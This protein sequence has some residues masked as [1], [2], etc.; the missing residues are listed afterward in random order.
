MPLPVHLLLDPACKI[1]PAWAVF[2]PGWYLHRYAEA[3]AVCAGQPELAV[4]VYYLRVG[5]RLG[6]SPSSLFDEGFYLARNPDIAE[7]VRAGNYHSG[8]DHFCQHGHR[9]TSPHWLFDDA[10]YGNLYE[11]M[12]L[13]NLDQH[14]CHGRYDHYLRS[15]QR[16]RR[17]GQ[18]LFDGGFY[19]ARAVEAGH[20]AAAI[21]A[22]GPYVHFLQR[23]G[24]GPELP[25]SIYFEP[26]WYLEQNPAA[27]AALERGLFA[28]ALHHYLC[29][30]GADFLDPV[31]QFSEQYYRQAYPDIGTAV[32]H[33][34]YRSGYQQFV[35]HGAFELRRPRADIDLMYYRDMN[36][37]VRNDLNTGEVRD[38]FAHLRLVGLKDNLA[39]CPP[40]PAP[41]VTEPATKQ[42]FLLRA[43]NNLAIFARR[44]LDFTVH[45]APD[46]TVLMVLHNK[47][48]LTMLALAS[49]RDNFS[50]GIELILVDND[51]TDDTRRIGDYVVGARILRNKTN[52]G[53]LR[54]A[55]L[56]LPH[57]TAPCLLYLN[58]DVELGHA[59]VAAALAR[60]A[61][62]ATIGA[63]A[64]KI[65]R[66]NGMLQEAGSIIWN[67]G[68]TIGYLRDGAPL[69][70]EA[71]FLRDVDYGSAVFLLCRAVAVRQLGGFDE[72]FSPAYYEDADLCVRMQ[73]AGYRVVYDP[74]VVVHHLEFGSASHSE[75]SMALMRRGKR[76]F[77]GKH[78]GFLE[79]KLAP[80]PGNILWARTV[81]RRQRRR[82][83]LFLEDTVPLRR[84]G[85]GF[86]R[87]N[88]VVHAIAGSGYDVDVFPI[89][90]ALHDVMSLFGD[91]PE[92]CEVLH[93][94]NF[95]VLPRFLEERRG[96]YDAIW[97][98]RTH[99]LNRV[100]PILREAGI[101]LPIVLD[102][103][104]IVANRQAARSAMRGGGKKF[105][106]K[107]ALRREFAE[108]GV[109]RHITA[110]NPREVEQLVA[111]GLP[112]SKLGTYR[113]AA[114][115]PAAF[116]A[117]EGLL[118][119]A[120]IHEQDSPN[121]DALRWYLEDILPALNAVMGS[122]P[123]L[124]VVGYVE[125]RIDL[126]E[127]ENHPQIR[128]HGA[129]GDLTPFY[130][131]ARLFIAPTRYAG[132]TPYKVYE[133]ASFGL[134]CVTT[135]LLAAQLG[136]QS[137]QELLSAAV[138][139][140]KGFA[141]QI[142]LAYAQEDLWRALRE[143]ALKRLRA[144]NDAQSFTD[145]VAGIL[146][147]LFY[148]ADQTRLSVV[149]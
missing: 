149:N 93:D 64:A 135:A 50:G 1:K 53:F 124:N 98:S 87:A 69:A 133:T 61:S 14:G 28:G 48:A 19:R 40:L 143:N 32:E 68:T 52:A 42:Q 84:L 141:A 47:L 4:L 21:D 109:C 54:G 23:L 38:A 101:D 100:L 92:T 123:V 88:D 90:G 55:N 112:A 30:E 49:L 13:E 41:L 12:S 35:Q 138:N 122:A 86:V 119:V 120:A 127:F 126:S 136:W 148:G 45:G 56:A 33:G 94:R 144:E 77:R 95:M 131:A 8:F 57:V 80:A 81:R 129:V 139:D 3:R 114:P 132:G 85:S 51:S 125:R 134:P 17:M 116:A 65:I 43:S 66:T 15:G 18:F 142:A 74:C 22:E 103:E 26:A 105:D 102:T 59:A 27:K 5:A 79:T 75:A 60:M 147:K 31:P 107:A 62:D 72:D 36:E 73:A 104:A 118:F 145:S 146:R 89:N 121:Y 34:F 25:P 140:A 6:H 20:A 29:S 113:A 82:R 37:R 2:A 67:E 24:G 9:G 115:T 108:A 46:V 16:E 128:L 97:I 58:N 7:L 130:D 76:I 71:T 117:R 11:D 111:L 96:Y 70:P 10:L 63:V 83:L 39:H 106:L 78:K 44:K 99:N 110:V 137:G 91:L